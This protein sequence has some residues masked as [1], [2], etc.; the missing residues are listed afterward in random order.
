MSRGARGFAT[1]A[2]VNVRRRRK[3]RAK[4]PVV[5]PLTGVGIRV[6]SLD[7]SSKA[8]GWAVFDDGQLVEYGRYNQVGDSHEER[9]SRFH[10]W[11]LEM[12]AQWKPTR[13]IYE[14]PYQGRMK[15]TFGVLSKY[16]GVIEAAYWT[17]FQAPVPPEDA[18]A[19]R[20]VK[21]TIGAQKGKDHEAN[22]RIVL[23]LVNQKFSL[24]LKFKANDTKKKVSQDDEADAIAL[25]WA[26][27]LL[28]YEGFDGRER[29][30]E[31]SSG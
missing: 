5:L 31:S 24:S 29:G 26:W 18:F 10:T 20:L 12:F 30:F 28:Y 3:P 8:C 21:K 4:K 11:L 1:K 23:L 7:S 13:V 19:A 6:L 22:K 25:N 15:N 27:H 9:L 16:I 17:H 2:K 14:L